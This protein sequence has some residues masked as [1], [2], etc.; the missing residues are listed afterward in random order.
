MSTP[1]PPTHPPQTPESAWPTLQKAIEVTPP[2]L[3]PPSFLHRLTRH[4][5]R[6]R[7]PS[8]ALP[9]GVTIL[10]YHSVVDPGALHDWERHYIK[11]QTTIQLFT[12]QMDIMTELMTPI[13]LSEVPALWQQGCPDRPFFAVTFDDGLQ[14]NLDV[15][16]LVLRSRGIRPTLFVNGAYAQGVVFYRI[17]VAILVGTGRAGALAAALRDAMPDL[18][19]SQEP[20]TL[21]NQTKQYYQPEKMEQ[22]VEQVYRDH[23]GNPGD[24]GAHLNVAGVRQLQRDGWEIGNHTFAHRILSHLTPQEVAW[25]VDHNAEFWQQQQIDLIPFLGYPVGRACDVHQPVH[26]YLSTRPGLHGMFANG[27]INL[28]ATQTEWLRCSLAQAN[29]RN[30]VLECLQKEYSRTKKA[31]HMIGRDMN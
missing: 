18:P 16:H 10:V 13:A 24:L 23:C 14:N 7:I 26:N 2:S 1:P 28:I 25:A 15:A 5:G 6:K 17:L 12:T 21:F 30:A 22:S 27:G 31:L 3:P 19:W 4:L 11:G 29:T 20:T 8:P 9:P